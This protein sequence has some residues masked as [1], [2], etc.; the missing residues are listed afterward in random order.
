MN[1]AIIN[2]LFPTPI[3]EDLLM[4]ISGCN[5]ISSLDCSS[6]FFQIPIKEEDRWKTA[7]RGP[8]GHYEWN[9]PHFGLK[10]ASAVFQRVMKQLLH[11]HS[12]YADVFIDDASVF[13]MT[14]KEHIKHLEAVLGEYLKVGMTLKMSK[15]VF[16]KSHVRY[17][18]H[19]IG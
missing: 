3:T 1:T 2:D 16:A 10:T 7:F 8:D 18:V 5:Y 11:K 4:K 9:V 6:G 15:C 13:S 14:W 17:L 19:V 12:K